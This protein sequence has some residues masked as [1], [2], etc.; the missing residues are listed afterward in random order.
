MPALT[1]PCGRAHPTRLLVLLVLAAFTL[2]PARPLLAVPVA[3]SRTVVSARPQAW[4]APQSAATVTETGFS[5]GSSPDR[6][7]DVLA[8]HAAYQSVAPAAL[9]TTQS[10]D[11][12]DI[13]VIEDDGTMLVPSGTHVEAD[14]VQV[15]RAFFRTHGDDYDYLCLY[16]ASSVPSWVLGG[17]ATAFEI[18][19]HQDVQGLG[20]K[21]FDYRLDFGSLGG[22][23][24]SILELNNLS[25]YPAD[26]LQDFNVS[27]N[28]MDA[29][30]HEAMHRWGAYV[31]VDSLGTSTLSLLESNRA[32]WQFYMDDQ[33][34]QLG[35]NQWQDN[36]NGSW[37]TVGATLRYGQLERYLG[38]FYAASEVDS[39]TILGAP[40]NCQPPANY[41]RDHH[42]LAGVTCDVS[43]YRFSIQNVITAN[44]PRVPDVSAS[45]KT[46]RFAF[47]LLI[48]H[49]TTPTQ[50]DLDKVGNIRALL[51]STFSDYTGGRGTAITTLV[52]H[53]GSVAVDVD[54]VPDSESPSASHPV[55]ARVTIV[56]GSL[57]LNVNPSG[58]QLSYGVNGG[59]LTTLPMTQGPA[60]TFTAAIPPVPSGSA[61][62]YFVRALSDSTGIEGYWPVGAPAVLDTFRVGPDLT[63][64]TVAFLA[65]PSEIKHGLLP[66]RFR[67]KAFDNLGLA[68]VFATFSV[69]DGPRDTLD[70]TRQGASDTFYVDV[71]PGAAPGDRLAIDAHAVDAAAVP[72]AATSAQCPAPGCGFEWGYDWLEPLD[73]SDG[74]L[75][76][77]AITAGLLDSWIWTAQSDATGRASWKCGDPGVLHYLAEIDA[78]LVTPPLL[79]TG[80][81]DLRFRHRYDLE[82]AAPGLAYDGAVVEMSV[83]GGA[84]TEITPSGGY[85]YVLSDF[86]GLPLPPGTAVYGG[87]SPG[88]DTGT[89]VDADFPVSSPDTET[90][91][92]RLRM[93]SDD[94]VG[95]GGWFVDDFRLVMASPPVAAGPGPASSLRFLAPAPNPARGAVRFAAELAEPS[96]VTLE[97]FDARGRRMSLAFH[98]KAPAGP[99]SL[100]W[101]PESGAAAPATAGLY[102]ARLT[103]IGAS[104]RSQSLS[105]RFVVLP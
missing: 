87:T 39:I 91:R 17:H 70:M 43:P 48:A 13:A 37:T 101:L 72:H 45:P 78:G 93:M 75:T 61:V 79:L 52:H 51:P 100:S 18:N 56:P 99:W 73:L 41:T 82:Q 16:T 85:P 28:T 15:A 10:Y 9:P 12:G 6:V 46:H 5:C 4:Q 25:I 2:I 32:H 74:G 42:P 53:A 69:N 98:G 83:R 30:C 105:R 1:K 81:A 76:S 24:H 68:R 86:S 103:T 14:E 7:L 97:I 3:S 20:L 27:N 34:S 63:P 49:G 44:G 96:Q 62:R 31:K 65:P 104:G 50:A 89:Y 47:I 26:P 92:F 64:P 77:S 66:Y 94:S 95:G 80:N 8:A 71:D 59:G 22:Q 11:H 23:L 21:L 90:V 57:P 36:G 19:V 40:G 67:A 29:L 88:F 58:V 38:G 102:F 84:W 60:G 54:P 35:G 55:T 33:A